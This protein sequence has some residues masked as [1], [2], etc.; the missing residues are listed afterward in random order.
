MIYNLIK[1]IDFIV[2]NN[3]QLN[4]QASNENNKGLDNNYYNN[5]YQINIDQMSN[6]RSNLSSNF[7]LNIALPAGIISDY[8][9]LL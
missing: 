6:G 8:K 3:N 5:S 9:E 4:L 1:E 7:Q 2:E